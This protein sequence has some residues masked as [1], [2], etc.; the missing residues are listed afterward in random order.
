MNKKTGS[1]AAVIICTSVIAG[2]SLF[3]FR[4]TPFDT[5]FPWDKAVHFLMYFILAFLTIQAFSFI[6]KKYRGTYTLAYVFLLG[7][8]I[9]LVQARLP[10][11][12]FELYDLLA[13]FLGG[14]A[15]LGVIW[16]T[17]FCKRTAGKTGR[18]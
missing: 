14:V 9:E 11:R 3:P 1:W 4:E 18:L 15:A 7:L 6:S 16:S 17:V 8:A 5:A 13:D 10:Y 12:S 2:L